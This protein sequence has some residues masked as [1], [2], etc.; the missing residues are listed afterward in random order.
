M[1]VARLIACTT[2][3]ALYGC[4]S[5]PESI[6]TPIGPDVREVRADPGGHVGE[7]VR[8]G[9]T[10]TEVKNLEQSTVVTVVARRTTRQGEP[11]GSEPSLG[12]FQIDV[13][14]FLDPE[15]YRPGRRVTA[16]GTIMEIRSG[17]IGEFVYDYPV[18]RAEDVYLWAEYV[19]RRDPYPYPYYFG[20][21]YDDP[22]WGH[23]W[24]RHYPWYY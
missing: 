14:R 1:L 5:V 20:W 6:S 7:K 24:H 15:E 19:R 22:F 12:R 4:A 16:V 17:K 9:G 13:N 18:V 21:P 8:W 3:L 11:L 2:V 10:I 23:P